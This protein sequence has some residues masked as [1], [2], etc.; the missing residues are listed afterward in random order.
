VGSGRS[1]RV[2]VRQASAGAASSGRDLR[3]VIPGLLAQG[4]REIIFTS[5]SRC[6]KNRM[7][8]IV[9]IPPHLIQAHVF[10]SVSVFSSL[11][12]PHTSQRQTH[13]NFSGRDRE[14]RV[15]NRWATLQMHPSASQDLR[16]R[17]RSNGYTVRY[18]RQRSVRRQPGH[19]ISTV[20]VKSPGLCARMTTE[21]GTKLLPLY[22]GSAAYW[23][24]LPC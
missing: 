10:I 9:E 20:A 16:D 1:Q 21:D 14:Q 13:G 2:R 3:R 19:Q 24:M 11:T 12:A 6:S 7:F 8:F 17:S 15:M 5:A 18:G 22:R 23:V 4:C